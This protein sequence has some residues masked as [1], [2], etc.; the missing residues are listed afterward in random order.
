MSESVTAHRPSLA[1][2]LAWT[3]HARSGDG[4]ARQGSSGKQG[5]SGDRAEAG[6]VRRDFW[7]K[8]RRVLARLPFAEDLT[9]A[10]FCALDPAT[11]GWV[12]ATLLG[13]LAY[14]IAPA[15]AIPDFVAALGYTDD[16]AVLLM[17]VRAVGGSITPSHRARAKSALESERG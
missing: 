13:A 6:R 16:A 15:D 4:A 10:Y 5:Y 1:R 12:K 2:A 17:A 14:F 3:R 8:L 11:P 9:A 7:P